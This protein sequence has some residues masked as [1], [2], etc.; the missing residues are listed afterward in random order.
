MNDLNLNEAWF[1]RSR[2]RRARIMDGLAVALLMV[3]MAAL[4][5]AVLLASAPQ[6]KADDEIS[7]DE[8]IFIEMYG[9]AVCST[10]DDYDSLSGVVGISDAI[11]ERGYSRDESID[12]INGSVWLYCDYHWPLLQAVGKAFRAVS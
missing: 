4:G 7:R 9:G 2:E 12:I 10:L 1:A 5:C 3:L 11:V 8:Q 6:A